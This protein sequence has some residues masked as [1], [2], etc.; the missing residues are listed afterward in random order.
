M[1]F[2]LRNLLEEIEA[3]KPVKPEKPTK[4]ENPTK[5]VPQNSNE[6]HIDDKG[7]TVRPSLKAESSQPSPVQNAQVSDADSPPPTKAVD[8]DEYMHR[9]QYRHIELTERLMIKK[10]ENKDTMQTVPDSTQN[11]KSTGVR[12]R[13]GVKA[14]TKSKT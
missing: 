11:Q 7:T 5:S 6:L 12:K 9:L 13:P 2:N 3:G 14:Y 10:P 1:P 8:I 4:E